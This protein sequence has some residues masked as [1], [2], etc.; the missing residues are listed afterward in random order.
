MP[1]SVCVWGCFLL[2]EGLCIYV[3][4]IGVPRLDTALGIETG[5]VTEMLMSF[6]LHRAP[7][8][9]PLSIRL[10]ETNATWA[11]KAMSK[12]AQREDIWLW[13]ASF[14]S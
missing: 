7:H 1:G 14:G 11:Q 9:S 10:K 6:V 5:S 2:C 4:N 8:I 12:T 3:T 13:S